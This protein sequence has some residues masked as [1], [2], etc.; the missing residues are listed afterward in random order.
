MPKAYFVACYREISDP[1]ALAAYAK[2][3]GPAVMASGGRVLA[4]GGRVQS[5]EGGI[6]LRTVVIEFDSFDAAVAFYHSDAYLQ[7][8][9]ALGDGAI[10]DIRVVEGIE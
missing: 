10:R 1:E 7:A 2:L 3:G 6:G 8:R 5:L 9:T 4:R